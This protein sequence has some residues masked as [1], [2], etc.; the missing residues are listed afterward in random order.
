MVNIGP[1]LRKYISPSG[2]TLFFSALFFAPSLSP[3]L[4]GWLN[5][6]LAI[7]V[8][9]LLTIN[10]GKTGIAQLRI[11][12]LIAGL[13][14]LL[15]QRLEIFL[16]SLTLIPLGY[17]LFKSAGTQESAALSGGKGVLVLSLTWL[18]FW[19]VYGVI[20]GTNPYNYLL[21]VLDLGFQQ[22]LEFYASKEAGLSQETIYTLQQVTNGMRKTI[23]NLLPGLLA[24]ALVITVWINMAFSNTL[25]ARFRNGALPWGEYST[26]KLPEHLV[27]IPIAAVIVLLIGQGFVQHVSGWMLLLS[28]LLYF[29]QGLA[30]CITLLERW[31]VPVFIRIML[32]FVLIIQSYGVLILTFLGLGDVWFNFRQKTEEQ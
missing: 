29:F 14:A 26:W 7:P 24:S 4:F 6:L 30:V 21:E 22:S 31:N 1:G 2:Q 3:L 15:A 27:W 17:S 20:A 8:F 5:G 23:P 25:V 10:G 19:G 11:S 32:Y 16:F 13:G 18:L 9:Y 28:G 12:L